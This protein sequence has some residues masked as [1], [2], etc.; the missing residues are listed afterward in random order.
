MI[1]Q[2]TTTI[3]VSFDDRARA[4]IK[5]LR[6]A[7]PSRDRLRSLQR[8]GVAVYPHQFKSL[9]AEGAVEEIHSGLWA[10]C[11]DVNYDNNLGLRTRAD[12]SVALII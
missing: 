3:L 2:A 11:S 10:L 7:G 4:A 1:D 12:A 6:F 8:Y 9:Q 5:E